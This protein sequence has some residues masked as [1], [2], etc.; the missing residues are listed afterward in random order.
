MDNQDKRLTSK[1]WL[2][3]NSALFESF[4]GKSVNVSIIDKKIPEPIKFS[5]SLTTVVPGK[6]TSMV[7]KPKKIALDDKMVSPICVSIKFDA[8]IFHIVIDKYTFLV[9]ISE[10]KRALKIDGKAHTIIITEK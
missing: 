5:T 10:G 1:E 3:Q 4:I 2:K 9:T 6:V 7:N 8:G